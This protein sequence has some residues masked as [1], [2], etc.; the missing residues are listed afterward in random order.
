MARTKNVIAP[1]D[2]RA[3]MAMDKRQ[4]EI[5]KAEQLYGDGLPFD[6]F[7][8]EAGI[9]ARTSNALALMIQNGKDYHRLKAH[10][11][12]G[13]FIA[14]VERTSMKSRSWVYYCMR[15][16]DMFLNVHQVN[17]SDLG[18]GHVRALTLFEKPVVEKYLDGG[19]L[20]DIP[21]DD[22]ATMPRGELEDEARR[23]RKKADAQKTKQEK[24]VKEMSE[25]LEML[26]L[27]DSNRPP[28]TKEDIALAELEAMG[29][30]Y[31]KSLAQ[32]AY[33]LTDAAEKVR[34]AQYIKNVDI[35]MLDNWL[36]KW[37]EELQM[38]DNARQ[39]L[40]DVIDNAGPVDRGSYMDGV[41]G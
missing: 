22:V 2:E 10:L 3:I 21:H 25:E 18:F 37:D 30:P 26:R 8:L 6:Q 34:N 36:H 1:N 40:G 5:E 24:V 41:E 14:S 7:R 27:R 38:I 19:P 4:E 35:R 12:H 33:H 23:L 11:P 32:A 16:A 15:A 29:E 28:A 31:F 39:Q 13:E 9:K 17:I 20:G